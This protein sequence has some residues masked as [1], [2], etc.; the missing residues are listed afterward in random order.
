MTEFFATPARGFETSAEAASRFRQ[1]WRDMK[2]LERLEAELQT[3][4][5]KGDIA[6]R[7]YTHLS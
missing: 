5:L 3:A 4:R 7:P 6:P 2:K 1:Q